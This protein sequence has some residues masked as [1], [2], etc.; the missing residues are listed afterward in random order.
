MSDC[1][2]IALRHKQDW[3]A[4]SVRISLSVRLL[5]DDG[6]LAVVRGVL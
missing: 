2:Q 6:L 4:M 3:W 1:V 5:R